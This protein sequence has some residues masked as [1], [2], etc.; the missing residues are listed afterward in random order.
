MM[1]TL[2]CVI[3]QVTV[4]DN[5]NGCYQKWKKG[6]TW[7]KPTKYSA[8][9]ISP[10]DYHENNARVIAVLQIKN[11]TII[12]LHLLIVERR[13]KMV[14]FGTFQFCWKFVE[15]TSYNFQSSRQIMTLRGVHHLLIVKRRRKMVASK[16]TV[17][18]RQTILPACWN[19][20]FEGCNFQKWS[21]FL[22]CVVSI[23]ALTV[24]GGV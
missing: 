18:I 22:K 19:M 14:G 23:W 1:L 24:M 6:D 5:D 20:F 21:P 16:M 15:I 8:V 10:S 17:S 4:F 3:I 12:I 13:R 2:C 9:W 7:W 11:R